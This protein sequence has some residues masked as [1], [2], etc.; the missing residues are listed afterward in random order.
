MFLYLIL[1]R[2]A[3]VKNR[4]YVVDLFWREL[5]RLKLSALVDAFLLVGAFV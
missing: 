3:Q 2:D 4:E 1:V 5:H